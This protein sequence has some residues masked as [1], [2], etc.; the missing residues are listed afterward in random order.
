ML[1]YLDDYL[2][3][4][5]RFFKTFSPFMGLVTRLEPLA[6]G[7]VR[8]GRETYRY[9][10]GLQGWISELD[11]LG[12]VRLPDEVIDMELPFSPE[13]LEKRFQMDKSDAK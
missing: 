11:A 5:P 8:V 9:F 10:I 13:E 3:V 4:E 12:F 1:L 6:N 2:S 7:R